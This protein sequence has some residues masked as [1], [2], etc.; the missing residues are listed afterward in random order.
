MLGHI[1]SH[2]L[3]LESRIVNKISQRLNSL[4]TKLEPVKLNFSKTLLYKITFYETFS[5][6][7]VELFSF[8]NSLRLSEN[9]PFSIFRSFTVTLSPSLK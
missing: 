4:K 7:P 5:V 1:C 2:S 3:S 9:F 6:L 8:S